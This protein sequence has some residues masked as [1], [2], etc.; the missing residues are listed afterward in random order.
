MAA[1]KAFFKRPFWHWP[2]IPY[3]VLGLVI[4]C[5]HFLF[6]RQFGIYEDDIAFVG[7]HYNLSG[8]LESLAAYLIFHFKS[9][10]AGRPLGE[11]IPIFLVLIFR[12]LGGL[13]SI[14][15]AGMISIYLNAC[16]VYTL[17]HKLSK[18]IL[19]AFLSTISFSLFPADTTQLFLTHNLNL[20]Y[21]LTF[22]LIAFFVYRS[23]IKWPAYL[24]LA[25]IPFIYETA[26][27]LFLA[28]PLLEQTINFDRNL[29]KKFLVH[30][31]IM[32]IIF[33]LY[34]LLRMAAGEDRVVKMVSSSY[35]GIPL[36]SIPFR[37]GFGFFLGPIGS[38]SALFSVPIETFKHLTHESLLGM[39][40]AIPFF[41]LVIPLLQHNRDESKNKI[42][43]QWNTGI[44]KLHTSAKPAT[45]IGL[46]L[47]ITSIL[48]FPLAY[49]LSFP[50]FPLS[51]YQG[52]LTSVHMSAALPGG[53]LI[54]SSLFLC[55]E[56]LKQNHQK[57]YALIAISLFF[58]LIVGYRIRIQQDFVLAWEKIRRMSTQVLAQIQDIGSKTDVFVDT[59]SLEETTYIEAYNNQFFVQEILSRCYE[60]PPDFE[61]Y[62]MMLSTAYFYDEFY[63]EDGQYFYDYTLRKSYQDP[64]LLENQDIIF[65]TWNGQRF[66]RQYGEIEILGKSFQLKP[67]GPSTIDQ[68]EKKPLYDWFFQP[69]YLEMEG[70]IELDTLFK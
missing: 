39:V 46:R 51:N 41:I 15:L 24:I 21:S 47:L 5:S 38:L 64:V 13:E 3:L 68:F 6:F 54:G 8:N 17:I 28:A 2:I 36:F 61:P 57:I 56:W 53:I 33:G 58:S 59:G 60:F 66:V 42:N 10:G 29:R 49:V 23:R 63:Y 62:I 48:M 20:Q 43:A 34:F 65:I 31:L 14:Y 4:Y 45:F 9:F 19:L 30:G 12:N 7:Y 70:P 1:N 67:P 27:W 55:Y 32:L 16:L 44:F 22:L 18:N 11:A 69:E 37:T 52:R 40:L 50:F 25:L 35:F 26:Y